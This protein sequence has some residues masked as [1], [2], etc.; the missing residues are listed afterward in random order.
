MPPPPHQG[1][2]RPRAGLG[3]LAVS[4][5][6][7]SVPGVALCPDRL[8]LM[9][10]SRYLVSQWAEPQGSGPA[11]PFLSWHWEVWPQAWL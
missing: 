7:A 6:E 4:N 9:L 5:N 10:G 11:D 2:M 1:Q 3:A 8:G